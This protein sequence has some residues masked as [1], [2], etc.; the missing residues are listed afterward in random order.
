MK[1]TLAVKKYKAGVDIKQAKC[2]FGQGE[3]PK[4]LYDGT[5]LIGTEEAI[6]AEL[7]ELWTQMKGDLG[8]ELAAGMAELRQLCDK[9]CHEGGGSRQGMLDLAK[10]W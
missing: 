6:K 10:Y 1:L 9:S 7:V 4:V 5:E 8:K 2:F 3:K